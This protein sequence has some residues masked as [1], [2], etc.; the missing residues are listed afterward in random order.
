MSEWNSIS[1][2]RPEIPDM[3]L[4][5]GSRIFS[6]IANKIFVVIKCYNVWRA[7]STEELVLN[8]DRATLFKNGFNC[9]EFFRR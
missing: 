5:S 2:E 3:N 7:R 8:Q 4:I 1:H 9:I 6:Q